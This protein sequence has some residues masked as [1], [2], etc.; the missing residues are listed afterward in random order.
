MRVQANSKGGSITDLGVN[1]H[2]RISHAVSVPL[3]L[4][5]CRGFCA[6]FSPF[7]SVQLFLS[8]VK[9]SISAPRNCH[10]PAA[11]ATKRSMTNNVA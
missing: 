10:F 4:S 9:P 2:A 3:F 5:S 8:F 1:I 11:K 7:L 6:A